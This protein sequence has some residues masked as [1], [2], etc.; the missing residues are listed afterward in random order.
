M[1]EPIVLD[2]NAWIAVLLKEEKAGAIEPLLQERSLAAP[3]LIRYET[4]NAILNAKKS[5]RPAIEHVS[6]KELFEIILEFPIQVI[7][8]EAWWKKSVKLVQQHDI[9]FYDSAYISAASVLG[10]PLLT[11]DKKVME[12][13]LLEKLELLKV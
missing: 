1:L 6:F 2:A 10:L 13:A 4:A 9:T 5:G 11:M 7:P 3:E 12:I 8:L